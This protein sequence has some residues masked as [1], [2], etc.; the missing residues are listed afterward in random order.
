[1]KFWDFIF[2]AVSGHSYEED[3]ILFVPGGGNELHN[4]AEMNL[5]S[6]LNRNFIV[7]V[8]KDSGAVDYED[9]LRKQSR[10]KNTVEQKGGEVLVLRKKRN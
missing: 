10:L 4:I 2:N 5:M 3:G 7:I 6:K 9:K 8:D 1:M